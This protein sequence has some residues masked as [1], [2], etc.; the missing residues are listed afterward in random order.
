MNHPITCST[1]SK[2]GSVFAYATGYDWS[3]GPQGYDQSK[4][5]P[6]IFLHEVKEPEVKNKKKQ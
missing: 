6:Q 2:D 3:Q 5:Q 1:F 4:M